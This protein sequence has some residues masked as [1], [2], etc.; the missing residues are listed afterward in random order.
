MGFDIKAAPNGIPCPTRSQLLT[1]PKQVHLFGSQVFKY[2]SLQE[3]FLFKSESLFFFFFKGYYTSTNGSLFWLIC[4]DYVN[5]GLLCMD[6]PI[7]HLLVLPLSPTLGTDLYFF[8][9]F[10][11]LM[12]CV[13]LTFTPPSKLFPDG[14][15]LPYSPKLVSSIFKP[16][17]P[18]DAAQIFL[19]VWLSDREWSTY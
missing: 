13:L 10:E 17:T 18:I 12:E 7:M 4:L 3:P 1:L 8:F 15:A 6:L 14:F 9:L 2:I 16:S 5:F 19:D 11:S